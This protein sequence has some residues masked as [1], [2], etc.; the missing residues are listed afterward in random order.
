M[1]DDSRYVDGEWPPRFAKPVP[2]QRGAAVLE[3]LEKRK[4]TKSA[5]EA[6]KRKVRQRDRVCRWPRCQHVKDD[7]R[8]EVSHLVSKGM[9][10]DKGIRSTADQM[11]LLCYLH[12]QGPE[13]LHSADLFIEAET[14]RGSDGA[15]AFWKL[16]ADGRRFLVA[17]EIAPFTYERD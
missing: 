10:G 7:V 9:G 2:K 14:E 6:E 17:R 1:T 15:L 3:R 12:H 5:E 8:L 4:V 11:V 16:D 13:S